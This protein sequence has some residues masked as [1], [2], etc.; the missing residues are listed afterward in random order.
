R[1]DRRARD[2]RDARKRVRHPRE[3]RNFG[4]RQLPFRLRARRFRRTE[5][6][7]AAFGVRRLAAALK[8]VNWLQSLPHQIPFRAASTAR[9]IDEK[10]IEGAFLCTANDQSP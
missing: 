2:R 8:A 6:G 9:V 4:S 5:D 10:T 1:F 3:K 7:G